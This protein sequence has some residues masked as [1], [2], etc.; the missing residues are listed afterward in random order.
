MEE[1]RRLLEWERE[2]RKEKRERERERE[3]ESSETYTHAHASAFTH[4][5]YIQQADMHTHCVPIIMYWQRVLWREGGREGGREGSDNL[6]R[7]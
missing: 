4:T 2:G 1:H 3:R 6:T 5:L 7:E